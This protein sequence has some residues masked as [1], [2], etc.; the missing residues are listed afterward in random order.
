MESSNLGNEDASG[1]HRLQCGDPQPV[2]NTSEQLYDS[3]L[4]AANVFTK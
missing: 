2:L 1:T 4:D 3:G